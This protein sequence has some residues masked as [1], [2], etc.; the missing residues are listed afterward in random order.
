[1]TVDM[2]GFGFG[3]MDWILY[4]ELLVDS[5]DTFIVDVKF[6]YIVI[7]VTC[8]VLYPEA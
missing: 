7:P 1:M 8:L 3:F 4:V 5:R 6:A 2:V